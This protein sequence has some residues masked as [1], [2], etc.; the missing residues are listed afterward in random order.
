[1]KRKGISTIVITIPFNSYNLVEEELVE[2]C[3]FKFQD[4]GRDAKGIGLK[5]FFPFQMARK[6][7]L[8]SL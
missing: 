2:N 4:W 8:C 1:M 3:H 6:T 5:G 7:H